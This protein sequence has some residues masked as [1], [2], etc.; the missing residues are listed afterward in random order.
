[1]PRNTTWDLSNPVIEP[2]QKGI[3]LMKQD[4]VSPLL[5]YVLQIIIVIFIVVIDV[6]DSLSFFFF[7]FQAHIHMSILDVLRLLMK[8]SKFL[9]I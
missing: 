1:M 7:F 2:F 9:S 4:L 5:Q 8:T 3:T 6:I